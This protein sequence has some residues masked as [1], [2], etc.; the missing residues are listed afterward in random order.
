MS[1]ARCFEVDNEKMLERMSWKGVSDPY[2]YYYSY[3]NHENDY[4]NVFEEKVK[5]NDDYEWGRK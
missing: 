2:T 5:N 1:Y 4:K 3:N